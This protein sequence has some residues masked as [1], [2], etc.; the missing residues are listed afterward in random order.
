M[1]LLHAFSNKL[2]FQRV[3]HQTLR[4]KKKWNGLINK[5]INVTIQFLI[6]IHSLTLTKESALFL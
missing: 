2:I 6:I 1:W 5:D 4:L 3:L